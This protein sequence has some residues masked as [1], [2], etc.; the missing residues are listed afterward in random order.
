MNKEKT[1]SEIPK[2]LQGILWSVNVAKLDLN[3][4]KNYI[5][6]QVL[7]YGSLE[8]ISWLFKVYGRQEVKEIF[9]K[10]PTRVYDQRSF[11]FI[12]NIVLDL[13]NASL[14]K[15]RYVQSIF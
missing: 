1:L 5:I 13:E 11:V 15:K 6:H 14:D 9:A 7:A 3:R 12:K 2:S 4:D 8:Q 10:E